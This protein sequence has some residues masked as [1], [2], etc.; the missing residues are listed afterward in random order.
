[1]DNS[2]AI[3]TIPATVSVFISCPN[4]PPVVVN[5]AKTIVEDGSGQIFLLSND[6]DLD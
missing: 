4:K 2:G 5:D 1:M 6:Y 3:S